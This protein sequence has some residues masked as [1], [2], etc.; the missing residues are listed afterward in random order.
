VFQM[1]RILLISLMLGYCTWVQ[2]APNA[3]NADELQQ[4]QLQ[5]LQQLANQSAANNNQSITVPT[6]QPTVSPRLAATV[7]PPATPQAVVTQP[8]PQSQGVP[9]ESLPTVDVGGNLSDEAFAN[10]AK[11]ALPLSPAQI[12]T[13]RLLFDA[14]QRA[15]AEYPGTP[16]QPTSS[17]VIVNLAPGAAPPVIRLTSGFVTS[18]VFL[19]S[20]GAPWP[21]KAYDMGDPRAFN[22]N[23]DKVGNTL[24]VQAITQYKVGNL[25]VILQGLNTPVMITLIP[26]QPAVDYRVDLRIP[27]LGP[28]AILTQLGLPGVGSPY[29]LNVLDG[30]PPPGSKQLQVTGGA[31]DIWLLNNKIYIRT[32]LTILSPGWISTLSSADG[33]HAYEMMPAPLILAS[34]QGKVMKLSIEG[35]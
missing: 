11:S 35:Y 13:L 8:V 3:A 17:S 31:A 27:G 5:R 15:A 12:R 19:D 14:N 10:V 28:N 2:A 9:L 29:L 16:P 18:M 6:I 32:R 34:Y 7:L 33:T 26:G 4:Q 22:V 23:W 21:I 24:L 30:I 1:K 25:A 20:T